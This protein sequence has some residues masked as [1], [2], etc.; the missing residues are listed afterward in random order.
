MFM[1]RR[2]KRKKVN[3]LLGMEKMKMLTSY[4]CLRIKIQEGGKLGKE[5][6]IERNIFEELNRL[7]GMSTT[8][9]KVIYFASILT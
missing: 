8:V 9:Q 3:V 5:R 2:A 7:P 4:K 6:N 1:T